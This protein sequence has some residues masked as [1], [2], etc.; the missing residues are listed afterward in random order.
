MIRDILSIHILRGNRSV[1]F[2]LEVKM[3]CSLSCFVCRPKLLCSTKYIKCSHS[4]ELFKF[5]LRKIAFRLHS[6][7]MYC[8]L[9]YFDMYCKSTGK[10]VLPVLL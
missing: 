5:G 3:K 10:I 6:R 4:E 8:S 1:F 2:N 7:Y 9:C